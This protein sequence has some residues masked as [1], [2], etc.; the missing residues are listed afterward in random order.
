MADY[1][2]KH[3]LSEAVKY[4][5]LEYNRDTVVPIE[6]L[7]SYMISNFRS[8]SANGYNSSSLDLPAGSKIYRCYSEFTQDV[9]NGTVVQIQP[10]NVLTVLGIDEQH[11]Y[12]LLMDIS[13]A[14][15]DI[16]VIGY[17]GMMINILYI[18]SK[19]LDH[20]S[21]GHAYLDR[22]FNSLTIYED[23]TIAFSNIFRLLKSTMRKF[24]SSRGSVN[25]LNLFTEYNL[26]G[27]VRLNRAKFYGPFSENAENAIY[28]GAPGFE[29]REALENHRFIAPVHMD[30]TISIISS[31]VVDSS[32]TTE[33][34]GLINVDTLYPNIYLASIK[35]LE[36]ILADEYPKDTVLWSNTFGTSDSLVTCQ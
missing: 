24:T 2:I 30:N 11:I 19:L 16:V 18:W 7:D 33:T 13:A 28:I 1:S 31:P 4:R 29:A 35:L 27:K 12:K 14:K 5:Y 21:I 32:I 34:Y 26:S 9:F 25:K 15:K 8:T 17:G 20:Y 22:L 36:L 23:D 10:I 6:V 3:I